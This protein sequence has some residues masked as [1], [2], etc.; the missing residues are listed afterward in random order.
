[1]II[2]NFK[3]KRN[4]FPFGN[5]ICGIGMIGVGAV[6]IPGTIFFLIS[7]IYISIVYEIFCSNIVRPRN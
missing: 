7:G 3:K 5:G 2:L 4:Y 6:G 1:M